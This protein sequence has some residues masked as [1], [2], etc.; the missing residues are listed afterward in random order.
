MVELLFGAR[1]YYGAQLERVTRL[2]ALP[3]PNQELVPINLLSTQSI[4]ASKTR[5]LTIR[6]MFGITLD[7]VASG[8]GS[9]QRG[10]VLVLF[11]RQGLAYITLR[12]TGLLWS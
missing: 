10:H 12:L 4:A 1:H 6:L 9:P 7:S 8:Y 5:A 11:C 2:Y 3:W